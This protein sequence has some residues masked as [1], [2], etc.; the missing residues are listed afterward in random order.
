MKKT[1]SS[2]LLLIGTILGAMAAAE[3]QKPWIA[4]PL[5][6]LAESAQPTRLYEAVGVFGADTPITAEVVNN[7]TSAGFTEV[8]VVRYPVTSETVPVGD[9]SALVERVLDV[10]V[11]VGGDV[12]GGELDPLPAGTFLDE[13]ALERLLAMGVDEVTLRVPKKWSMNRW[14]AAPWFGA[15]IAMM[16]A[17]VFLN[18]SGGGAEGAKEATENSAYAELKGLLGEV[19]GGAAALVERIEQLSPE[20]GAAEIETCGE[21]V[22]TLVEQRQVLAQ[23]LG[24]GPYAEFMGQFSAAERDLNRA[25]SAAVDGYPQEA[26]ESL[27]RAAAGFDGA[28]QR[29]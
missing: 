8:K 23:A 22:L 9:G 13:A 29:L 15:A 26:R 24:A 3:G 12:S 19:G 20:G 16:L 14:G 18:R 10:D 25:W 2:M 17:A 28:L 27:E 4:A 5:E 21:G 6:G 7:L 11:G 1:L